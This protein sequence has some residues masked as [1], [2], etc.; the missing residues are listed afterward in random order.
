MSDVLRGRMRRLRRI[1]HLIMSEVLKIERPGA[2][3]E[4]FL[5]RLRTRG[6]VRR[7]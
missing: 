2:A 4:N 1:A 3:L 7:G 6:K 5:N